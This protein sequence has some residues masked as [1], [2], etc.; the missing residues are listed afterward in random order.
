MVFS[1]TE[2]TAYEIAVPV[3]KALGYDVYDVVYIKEG[4]HW[5]LRI[6]ITSENGVNLTDCEEISR[7]I[8][9]VLDEKDFIENNYFLEVSSPGIERVLRQNEHFED[10]IGENIHL[11][12]FGAING[13]KEAD[14]ELVAVDTAEIKIINNGK[15]LIIERKNIA[16][17]NVLF[18]F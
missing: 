9:K 13:A 11:K 3:A 1:K 12:L 18:D 2:N 7:G 16:K 4:P 10:A 17:A 14:G 5:F 8:S 6:F 15:E